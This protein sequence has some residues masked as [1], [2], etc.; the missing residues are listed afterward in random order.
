MQVTGMCRLLVLICSAVLIAAGADEESGLE[1]VFP[2][3]GIAPRGDAVRHLL[4]SVCPGTIV[5]QGDNLA[6]GVATPEQPNRAWKAPNE[7]D[8]VMFGH[9]LGANSEDAVVS[10]ATS[11]THPNRWG[12]TLFL[13][14]KNGTWIPLWYKSGVITRHCLPFPSPRG[15]EVLVCASGYT[16]MGH[17]TIALYVLTFSRTGVTN[18]LILETD[19]FDWRD[20]TPALAPKQDLISVK[21]VRTAEKP[22]LEVRLQHGRHRGR[23]ATRD[24]FSSGFPTSVRMLRFTLDGTRFKP[25]ET[26]APVLDALFS[27]PALSRK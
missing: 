9:F 7:V 6:C 8:R 14:K 15:N 24:P 11:E 20:Q 21:R 13:T 19:T 1:S 16:G 23:A 18:Q 17:R 22:L 26:D 27:D 5:A 4:K 2:R 10:G 3:Y 12:A 25:L